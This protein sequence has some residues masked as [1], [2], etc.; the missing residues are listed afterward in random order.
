M[1]GNPEATYLVRSRGT[2]RKRW[3]NGGDGVVHE[4]DATGFQGFTFPIGCASFSIPAKSESIGTT[5]R[6]ALGKTAP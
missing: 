2:G 6:L 1:A 4:V 5:R 3:L